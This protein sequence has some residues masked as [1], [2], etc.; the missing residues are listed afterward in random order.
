MKIDQLQAVMRRIESL[1]VCYAQV[2]D[3]SV[4]HSCLRIR[5][6]NTFCGLFL[7]N[8]SRVSFE[9]TWNMNAFNMEPLPADRTVRVHVHSGPQF[10]VECGGAQFIEDM[11][12][13]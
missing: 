13:F 6:G 7:D 11:K 12:L 8:C 4:S 10:D 3:Y 2:W 9:P 5:F 1:G